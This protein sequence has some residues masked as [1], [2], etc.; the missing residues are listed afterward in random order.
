M[1]D[2]MARS[3]FRFGNLKANTAT[4]FLVPPPDRLA[5]YS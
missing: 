4:V 5:A 2:V 1:T 3:D